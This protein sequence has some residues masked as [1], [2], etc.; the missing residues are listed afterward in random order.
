[1]AIDKKKKND[2]TDSISWKVVTYAGKDVSE[3]KG[4]TYTGYAEARVAAATY[5]RET[6]L[7]ATPIRS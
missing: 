1:M 4:L 7:G 6:G 5:T 3:K 2:S